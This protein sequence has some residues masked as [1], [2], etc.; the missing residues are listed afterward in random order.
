MPKDARREPALARLSESQLEAYRAPGAHIVEQ[1][2]S[3]ER[4]LTPPPLSLESVHSMARDILHRTRS[5]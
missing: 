3:G 5:L 1:I 2:C 4:S